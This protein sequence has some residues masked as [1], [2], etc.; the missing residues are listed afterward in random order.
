MVDPSVIFGGA[1]N[2]LGGWSISLSWM[3][4]QFLG[5]L[6]YS[7]VLDGNLILWV[8]CPSVSFGG[9]L[10]LLVVIPSV[11]HGR[12]VNFLGGWCIRLFWTVS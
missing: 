1:L 5:W 6:V 3:V 12:C 2:Y 11:S 10:I 4:R 9:A 8:V 7:F